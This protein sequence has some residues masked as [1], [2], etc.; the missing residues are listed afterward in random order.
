MKNYNL[1]IFFCFILLIGCNVKSIIVRDRDGDGISNS[2]DLCPEE[3]GLPEFQGCP[4]KDRDGIPDKDDECPDTFGPAVNMGCPWPDTDGDGVLD[5]DDG[6]LDTLGPAE[7]NG[8]PWP[9]ID[10][11]N[12]LD[13]DDACPTVPGSPNNHGCPIHLVG[14]PAEEYNLRKFP[15]NPPNPSDFEVLSANIFQNDTTFEAV[16]QRLLRALSNQNCKR[17]SYY[18]IDNGF[19]LI[20]QLEQIDGNGKYL[21]CSTEIIKN[22]VFSPMKYLK[23]L[24]TPQTGYYRF[25]VF[26]IKNT[27]LNFSDTEINLPLT[28]KLTREGA[29][30]LPEAMGEKLFTSNHRVTALIYQ[31]KKPEHS[32]AIL[33]KQTVPARHLTISGIEQNLTP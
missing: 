3:N 31:F 25:F 11:D 20:T 18:D 33:L 8:C 24:L 10:G 9:D 2:N 21:S 30:Y 27:P 26:I 16:N 15:E 5:K 12:V 13:K 32:E 14:N 19:V 1:L 22:D 7:N 23:S 4:D 29:T 28:Q 17:T 6:C